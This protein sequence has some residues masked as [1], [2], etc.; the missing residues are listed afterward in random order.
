[1]SE[2]HRRIEALRK[3][4][5]PMAQGDDAHDMDKYDITEGMEWMA[6]EIAILKDALR[7]QV[8]H[9]DQAMNNEDCGPW[10]EA[11]Q[12]AKKIIST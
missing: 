9:F 12:N 4:G 10:F 7:T 8:Y 5:F 1:M 2:H 3:A 11:V 6:G